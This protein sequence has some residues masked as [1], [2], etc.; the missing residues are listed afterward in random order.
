MTQFR[1][2]CMAY[3]LA[4]TMMRKKQRVGRCRRRDVIDHGCYILLPT[5][6]LQHRLK[7]RSLARFKRVSRDIITAVYHSA[8]MHIYITKLRFDIVM[9]IDAGVPAG[10]FAGDAIL[11]VRL[12]L[13]QNF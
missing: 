7:R 6:C 8:L 1:L 11:V 5:A 3:L 10:L 9:L 13:R 4:R 2:Y 12:R